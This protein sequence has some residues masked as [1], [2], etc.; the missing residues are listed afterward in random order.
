MRNWSEKS[1][2]NL[3][4]ELEKLM[5]DLNILLGKDKYKLTSLL[6]IEEELSFRE[7]NNK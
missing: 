7:Y 3:I 4:S 5:S 6:G 2:E 1:T